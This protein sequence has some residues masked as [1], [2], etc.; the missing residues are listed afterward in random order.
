MARPTV[1]PVN[2]VAEFKLN[3][4][5][6]STTDLKGHITS[7]NDVF[8]DIAG[9]EPDEILDAPHN[10]IRHPDMPKCVFDL[11]WDYLGSGRAL[12]AYVKNMSAQ[13]HYYW[14]YALALPVEDGFLSVRLKPTSQVF[15]TVTELYGQL[16][17]TE[18]SHGD[19]WRAG[20]A[21]AREEL[22]ATLAAQGF[23]SYDQFMV[24]CLRAEL[25]SRNEIL[26]EEARA[27]LPAETRRLIDVFSKLGHLDTLKHQASEQA[28]FLSTVS[29]SI[30]RIA[31]NSS[32]CAA[33]MDER[34]QALGVLSDQASVISSEIATGAGELEQGQQQLT[35]NL[36]TTAFQVACATLLSEMGARFERQADLSPVARE[37]QLSKY[38]KSSEDLSE[39]LS[40]AL[41]S[42]LRSALGGV[43]ELQ[44][45][46]RS[47]NFVTERFA[48]SLLTTRINHITGRS[49]A[50]N[51]DGGELYSNLLDEM[52]VIAEDA[53]SK[54]DD[55]Q[56]AI[57]I[58]D[59]TLRSWKLES[60]AA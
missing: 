28:E 10:V 25:C 2:Q 41:A 20:M 17:A 33:K 49:I 6:F 54:L 48:K 35:D 26:G 42:T 7:C 37:Q 14:V 3:D 51:I 40:T 36:T 32:V 16:L 13:G 45:T 60:R 43:K 38:G 47:F 4:L 19:D 39:M 9:Y 53:R 50:A 34:G 5:F 52:A 59:R 23:E 30:N 18:K 27:S 12:G 56:S 44:G 55:L 24:H 22:L 58:V 31:L 21:A 15:A 11:L 1:T 29:Q 57:N 8:L 46:L